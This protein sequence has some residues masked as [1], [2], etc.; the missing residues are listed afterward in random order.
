MAH[1]P[2]GTTVTDK[3]QVTIPVDVRRALG[4]KPRDKVSIEYDADRGVAVIRPLPSVVAMLYGAVRTSRHPED[5]RA[6]RAEFE[7]GVAEEAASEDQ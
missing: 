7:R 3:G 5:F 1:P 6:L 4:L 2:T